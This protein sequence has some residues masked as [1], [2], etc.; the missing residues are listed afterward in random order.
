MKIF[1]GSPSIP[2]KKRFNFYLDKAKNK[3]WL[4]SNG[5]LLRLLKKRIEKRLKTKNIVFVTSGTVGLI[6]ALRVLGVK[7]NVVTTP[8]TFVATAN[9][10][11]F[12]SLNVKFSDITK[13]NLNLDYNKINFN[14]L[15]KKDAIIPVHSFGIPVD[16]RK[17]D[18]KGK[19]TN[20]IYDAAHCFD[21]KFQKKSILNY[22]DASVLS[23]QAT[24]V[25]NTC[26]GGIVVFKKR[27]NYLKAQKYINFGEYNE[28]KTTV[29]SYLKGKGVNFKMNELQAA[30]GLSLLEEF[31]EIKKKRKKIFNFYLNKLNQTLIIPTRKLK[32][33]NFCYFPVIFK[34]EKAVNQAIKKLNMINVFPKKYFYPSLNT[35]AI[36]KGK[37]FP[38][39]E[40]I[41]K[42]I[43]CLPIYEKIAKKTLEKIVKSLNKFN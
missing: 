35:L 10:A 5:I 18:K 2:K 13:S 3:K 30:W 17:F 43:L 34:S 4:T 6:L 40:D 27:E 36:Y 22:G 31:D 8:F 28:N 11:K 29:S 33:N 23:L 20:I 26:E 9:A 16:I 38:V 25:F 21:I 41:A 42:K 39:S 7:R 12:L 19:K 1:T 24:K 32:S 14:K 15:T 37:K